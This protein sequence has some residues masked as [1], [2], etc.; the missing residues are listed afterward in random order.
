MKEIETW[1]YYENK[2]PLYIKNSFG[3]VDHFKTYFAIFN[4]FINVREK[5]YKDANIMNINTYKDDISNINKDV[6]DKIG[7]LYG[8]SRKF[9]FKYTLNNKETTVDTSTLNN[10]RGLNDKEFLRYIQIHILNQYFDGTNSS[11]YLMYRRNNIPIYYIYGNDPAECNIYYIKDSPNELSEVEEGMF[12]AGLYT[13]KS[14]GIKYN[15]SI[16]TSLVGIWDLEG[17]EKGVW[18]KAYWG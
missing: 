7:S 14:M 6:L 4:N 13:V 10:G 8:L 9:K 3:L 11:L 2:L 5:F 18:N 12:Y 15:Y 1:E 16:S 17:N